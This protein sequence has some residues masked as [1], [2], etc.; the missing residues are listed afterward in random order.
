MSK[1]KIIEIINP[2]N[3]PQY[4]KSAVKATPVVARAVFLFSTFFLLLLIFLVGKVFNVMKRI[5]LLGKAFVILGGLYEKNFGKLTQRVTDK[6]ETARPSEVKRVYLIELAYRNMMIKKTRSLIT[7][8]GMSIGV[9]AIVLL[10]SLGYGIERLIINKVARLDELKMLDIS[11]GENT[12]LRLNEEVFRKIESFKESLKALP[13][14]SVVGRINYNRAQTDVL[15]YAVSKDYLMNGINTKFIKGKPFANNNAIGGKLGKIE[16]EG[17]VAGAS[18]ALIDAK[19]GE[20]F[21]SGKTVFNISPV[22]PAVVWEECNISSKVLGY[23]IRIEGGFEGESVW[24]GDYYPFSENGRVGYDRKK[25]LFLGK[26]VKGKLPLYEKK[27]DDT[28]VPKFDDNGRHDWQTGCVPLRD[29]QL[30]SQLDFGSVLGESTD[31]ATLALNNSSTASDE[32]SIASDSAL[33]DA[34]V[35]ASDESGLETVSLQA[36]DS[37]KTKEVKT[38]KFEH[39]PDGDA[40][41]SSGFINLLGIDIN[42]AVGTT[43]K[44]S[45]IIVK[46]LMPDIEGKVFTSEV[47]YKITG[48]IEDDDNTYFYVP[49]EDLYKLGIKNFSQFKMILKNQK[50]LPKV[51]KDIETMGFRTNSTFDTVKQIESLF[52]NLRV[53]LAILGMVALGVASLGMF[54]TLTVSLLE[55]TRETGGM[56]AIGM[57]S[58]EV[59][60][61]F[62]AEAMIMGLSG[63]IGG[64]IF[65]S[66]IGTGLSVLVSIFAI[67]QGQGFLQ[68]NYLPPTFVL[69]I[70]ISAF[71]V[72]L[73]TGL[74]PAYRAKKTSALNALRYE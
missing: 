36:S 16:G 66:L 15:V 46:S 10:L 38:L 2:K 6:L 22:K 61:L 74:Y 41:V 49:F 42:K 45:F 58:D 62:L 12:A 32:A 13:V 56:K 27:A 60:D 48:V 72:G 55:R 73:L 9:G 25:N 1:E 4:F 24:G 19:M 21:E 71:I 68:L 43:F 53:L 54:N 35:I 44:S 65:G 40:V 64:L 69:F 26:W 37:A 34:T 31:S 52:A 39:K 50:D 5:P 70:I 11:A 18:T 7:I 57:V 47:E 59:Q 63:G 67:S 23:S 51:R 29:I 14:I 20:K 3:W 30:I 8:F 17:V 33:Y 28:I